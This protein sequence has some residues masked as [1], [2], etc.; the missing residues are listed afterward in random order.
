MTA[1][2]DWLGVLA[3]RGSDA[4]QFSHSQLANDVKALPDA[5]WQWNTLLQIQGRVLA[6]VLL[7]RRAENEVLLLLPREIREDVRATLTRYV[8]RSRV[9]IE[10]D[11]SVQLLGTLAG[12]VCGS[13]VPAAGGALEVRDGGIELHLGGRFDRR[14]RLESDNAGRRE[15]APVAPP[16]ADGWREADIIDAVPWIRSATAGEFIP[17]ALALD[18][19]GA[20]SVSKGCYP[21][22]EI[23]ARTHF[24]GRNKR[25]LR[26]LSGTHE[27]ALLPPGARL[28]ATHDGSGDPVASV[29]DAVRQHDGKIAGLCVARD[30]DLAEAWLTEPGAVGRF[31]L[32]EI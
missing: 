25:V 16:A 26:R 4:V 13:D 28:R 21:G 24:L 14:L 7:A 22:Q 27:C 19:L 29:V 17:Q 20:F 31:D 15:P 12:S 23:V 8:L 11:D 32:H 2:I 10:A 3:I 30:R 6:L 18:R 1:P 5:H 9:R